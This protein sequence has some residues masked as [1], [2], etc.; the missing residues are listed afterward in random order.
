MKEGTDSILNW[1]ENILLC[2]LAGYSNIRDKENEVSCLSTNVSFPDI[3]QIH[4]VCDCLPALY[5]KQ[6]TSTFVWLVVVRADTRNFKVSKKSL[7]LARKPNLAQL[8]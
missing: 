7:F 6:K 5:F 3:Q 2:T 8:I 1:A 4:I